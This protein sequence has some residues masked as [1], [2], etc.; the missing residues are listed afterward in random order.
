M[1]RLS[2]R[3]FLKGAVGLGLGAIGVATVLENL[4]RTSTTSEAGTGELP[5]YARPA[6]FFIP[7]EGNTRCGD[8]HTDDQPSRLTFCHTEHAGNYVKCGLCPKGCLI[9]EGHRGDCQVRENRGG[10]LYTMTYGNPCAVHNDPI[11]K[12]PFYHYLPGSLAFSLATA[13]CNLH[14][15]YC[16]NWQISQVPPEQT[17][18]INLPPE[19]VVT[20]AQKQGSA[21]IAFTYSEPIVFYEYVVDTA[22]IAR[23]RGVRCVVVSAGYI[24]QEP[25]RELCTVV[26]A[27]KIDLKG[28]NE[29][30]YE[31]VCSATLGPVLET[32]RTIARSGVHLEIVNLVVP[33]HND[34]P[35]DMRTLAK[36]VR[37]EVGPDVPLHFSRFG[38]MYRLKNLPPTPVQSLE[39]ARDIALEEGLKFVYLGNVPGHPAN[40]TYCPQC[41]DAIIL[42]SGFE[43]VEMHLQDGRCAFCGEEIPGV[44]E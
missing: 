31:E 36:W 21:S 30:F 11:E 34:D 38:P 35:E 23:S 17:Q 14:C 43:V 9:S 42:R 41:G 1:G 20:S 6:R 26:D 13:G 4:G 18:F 3:D 10:T 22:R 25:L 27:I 15:L 29:D 2:R 19:E 32:I 8:C 40:H 37:N 28:M 24:N 5:F 44:W 7:V 33:R 12:K 39:Q 16:Q